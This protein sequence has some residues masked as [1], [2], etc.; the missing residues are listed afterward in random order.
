MFYSRILS[1][2]QLLR[3]SSDVLP[4]VLLLDIK[5]KGEE[6]K[7]DKTTMPLAALG[8]SWKGKKFGIGL[9]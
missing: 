1:D 2:L 4:F 5:T 8:L 7:K 6:L 9:L 3:E